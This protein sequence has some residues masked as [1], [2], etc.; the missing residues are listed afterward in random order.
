[1]CKDAGDEVDAIKLILI[2]FSTLTS[3]NL[4]KVPRTILTNTFNGAVVNK[5]G[6]WIYVMLESW[7]RFNVE[8]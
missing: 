1:M 6:R 8:G 5:E 4:R 3:L 2:Y 7:K